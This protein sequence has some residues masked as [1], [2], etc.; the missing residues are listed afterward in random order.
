[1]QNGWNKQALFKKSNRLGSISEFRVSFLPN[2][3][4]GRG[5]VGHVAAFSAAL[6]R[7]IVTRSSELKKNPTMHCTLCHH[8][9]C[10]KFN[11][12]IPFGIVHGQL[13]SMMLCIT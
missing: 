11:T 10:S 12:R 13:T 6:P 1:M 9:H 2:A 4:S 3:I 5:D 7:W 8:D